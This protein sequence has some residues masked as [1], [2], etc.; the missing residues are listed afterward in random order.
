MRFKGIVLE[1]LQLNGDGSGDFYV[2]ATEDLIKALDDIREGKGFNDLVKSLDNDVYY[3][4]YVGFEP[5]KKE[6]CLIGTA[7]H[8]EKDDWENYTIPLSPEEKELLMFY[9][10]D[11][12][13]KEVG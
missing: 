8:S 4:F 13:A 9:I 3:N 6:I 10:I 5:N 2:P 11:A 1:E 12:L 7:N